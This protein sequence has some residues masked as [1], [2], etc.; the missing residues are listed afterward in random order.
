M[1]QIFKSLLQD[2]DFKKNGYLFVSQFIGNDEIDKL[3]EV[4][5]QN[6]ETNEGMVLTN[7]LSSIKNKKTIQDSISSIVLPKSLEYI[8]D[9]K[10]VHGIYA[11]KSNKEESSMCYHRDWSLV[12]ENL[13]TSLSCWVLLKGSGSESGLLKVLE[14]T[15]KGKIPY[16]GRNFPF[17][18][19]AETIKNI[20]PKSFEMKPG[21][22]VFFDHRLVHGSDTNKGSEGRL[23]AV[24]AMIPK[25]ASLLH[26]YRDVTH[27]SRVEVLE[28]DEQNFY[29]QNFRENSS[30]PVYLKKVNTFYL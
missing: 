6:K 22:A 29:Q 16:R 30:L 21:D 4:F 26:Y 20:L 1:R 12:D 3:I 15:H 28:L 5:N 8:I 13:F 9:Y 11:Y 17:E 18:I 14:G 24:L 2:N 27:P 23:A 25:E 10:P 19:E 7:M